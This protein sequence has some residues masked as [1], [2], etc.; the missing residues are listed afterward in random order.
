MFYTARRATRASAS[1]VGTPIGVIASPDLRIWRF[2]RYAGF[3]GQR[4]QPDPIDAILLRVGDT[5]RAYYRVGQGGGIQSST[6]AGLAHW[7]HLG[8]LAG[9]ID[10]PAAQRGFDYQEAPDVFRFAGAFW[11]LTDPHRGLAVFRSAAGSRRK[12]P[13]RSCSTKFIGGR[14]D[15]SLTSGAA[16]SGFTPGLAHSRHRARRSRS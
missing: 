12:P 4:G 9:D 2:L 6:S 15:F 10:A 14:I 13:T 5:F 7:R 1:Y 8:K 16:A 11:M 3:D